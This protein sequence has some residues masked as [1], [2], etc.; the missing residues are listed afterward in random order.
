MRLFEQYARVYTEWREIPPDKVEAELDF[1]QRRTDIFDS[2]QVK[3]VRVWLESG[4][5]LRVNAWFGHYKN[6]RA[7]QES[8]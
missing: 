6:Y 2:R 7:E 8:L 3:D 1:M 4:K 5:I